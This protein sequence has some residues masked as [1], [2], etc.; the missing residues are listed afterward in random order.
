MGNS[1]CSGQESVDENNT[2][3]ESR[4]ISKDSTQLPNSIEWLLMKYYQDIDTI[5]NNIIVF[6]NGKSMKFDDN[7]QKNVVELLDNPDVEDQFR[8]DYNLSKNASSNT[9]A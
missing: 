1:S 4:L 5:K 8:F 6:K 7:L 2:T 9:D 3:S